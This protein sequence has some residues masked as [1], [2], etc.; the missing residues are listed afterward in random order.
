M[1]SQVKLAVVVKVMGRNKRPGD[2]G[3]SQV[4]G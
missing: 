4:F 1:D 2:S 3:S